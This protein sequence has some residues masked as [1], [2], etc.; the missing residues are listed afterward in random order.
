MDQAVLGKI[1]PTEILARIERGVH[2]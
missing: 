2:P 1:G